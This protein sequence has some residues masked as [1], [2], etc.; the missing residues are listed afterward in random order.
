MAIVL[1]LPVLILQVG[2]GPTTHCI[3]IP[4]AIAC[5]YA[6]M[7]VHRLHSATLTRSSWFHLL[8]RS[9]LVGTILSTAAIGIFSWAGPGMSDMGRLAASA[10]SNSV[11]SVPAVM[12]AL[13]ARAYYEA[14][15][16][17][18]MVA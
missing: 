11:L 8:R 16:T 13:L 2:R 15:E 9:F 7:A 17:A 10:L 18:A 5:A 1:G 6:L 12:W 4:L 14:R 3:S